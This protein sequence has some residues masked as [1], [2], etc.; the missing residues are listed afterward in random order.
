MTRYRVG[1]C[2][3]CGGKP[4]RSGKRDHNLERHREH[5]LRREIAWYGTKRWPRLR[6]ERHVAWWAK[7]AE[8]A[9]ARAQRARVAP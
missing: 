4:L 3:V 9:A 5:N 6:V 2:L 8:R 1:P 7:R